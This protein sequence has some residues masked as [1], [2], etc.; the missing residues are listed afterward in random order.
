MPFIGFPITSQNVKKKSREFPLGGP[1]PCGKTGLAPCRQSTFSSFLVFSFFFFSHL[2]FFWV[3]QISKFKPKNPRYKIR[4]LKSP[5][6][7]MKRSLENI[8]FLF[9]SFYHCFLCRSLDFPSR[10][11]TSKKNRESS[12]EG[13]PSPCGKTGLAPCRQSIFSS[14]L[15]LSF[16]FSHLFF[17][18]WT[19]PPNSNP[20]IQDTK[21]DLQNHPPKT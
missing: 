5:Q 20:I 16:S 8:V 13:G 6:N 4:P 1:S 14:F 17:F 21:S 15:V 11:K 2:F 9:L 12:P 3:D 18:G 19:K 10:P 7:K